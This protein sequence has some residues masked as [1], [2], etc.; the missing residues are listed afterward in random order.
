MKSITEIIGGAQILF[1]ISFDIQDSFEDYLTTKHRAFL[2]M[3][4]IVE[5]YFPAVASSYHGRGRRPHD[6]I[7]IIR[8]FMAKSFFQI[9]TTVALVER[10]QSDSSLRRICGFKIVPSPSTFSRR[11]A[12][13]ANSH[14]LEQ[15]LSAMVAHYYK[16]AIVGH[17][18]RDST[19]I[20]AREK[21]IKSRE[22]EKPTP[23]RKRGRPKKGE[24]RPKDKTR[25][26]KQLQQSPE[27]ALS[28]LNTQ[29][30][31]GCKKN[32][33]GKIASWKGYKLHLDVTDHGIPI[34]SVVTGAN[35]HD[36]QV[37]IP[38]EKLSMSRITHCY[39][40]MDAGYDAETI[41]DFIKDQG[42]VAIVDRNNRRKQQRPP[43]CP[44]TKERYKVRSTVERSNAHL[45]D[46]LLPKKL[47]VRGHS[48]VQFTLMTGVV[49][50]AGIKILQLFY[51]P[52]EQQHAA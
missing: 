13:Y 11:L 47:M 43:M 17:L 27:S 19:P 46:W 28:Q 14:L 12:V 18:S 25:L 7:A 40:V 48:K 38:M 22:N 33:Q 23:K 24:E 41:R 16:D 20:P 42:R 39:S 37:A 9:E 6:D 15:A 51:L 26:E 5:E 1:N 50:L 44:A 4:Q 21:P 3:L 30:A 34:T 52:P 45:K 2:H 36:S 8:A 32:S 31:W 35:V 49:C 29:C 10:L